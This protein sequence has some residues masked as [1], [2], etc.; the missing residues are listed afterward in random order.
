MWYK[1]NSTSKSMFPLR[2]ILCNWA[3]NLLKQ[4]CHVN[5]RLEGLVE[6]RQ[7]VRRKEGW[8]GTLT[9]GRVWEKKCAKCIWK[10]V[11]QGL[12]WGSAS[13]GQKAR[14]KSNSP[15]LNA[16]NRVVILF[17]MGVKSQGKLLSREVL[18]GYPDIR[19]SWE[20]CRRYVG[21]KQTGE[22]AV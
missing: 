20:V 2:H 8:K 3:D 11:V 9:R 13:Q 19:F 18:R 4:Q 1:I 10:P 12:F 21:W 17:F 14:L 15:F 16:R 22:G 6:S 5:L 7:E